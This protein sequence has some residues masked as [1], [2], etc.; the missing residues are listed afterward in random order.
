MRR[1]L[2]VAVTVVLVAV[3]VCTPSREPLSA[4]APD[5]AAKAAHNPSTDE[6]AVRVVSSAPQVGQLSNAHQVLSF[7]R[8][9]QSPAMQSS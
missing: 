1:S 7:I 3:G 5:R 4:A 9:G 8:P 6:F 2:S